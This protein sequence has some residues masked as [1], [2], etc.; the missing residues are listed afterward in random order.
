[1][2]KPARA[3]C[4]RLSSCPA[5]YCVSSAYITLYYITLSKQVDSLG[6]VDR[7]KVNLWTNG[8]QEMGC[9]KGVMWCCAVEV[10]RE[11]FQAPVAGGPC[12]GLMDG[13]MGL[14]TMSVNLSGVVGRFGLGSGVGDGR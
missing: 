3:G 11:S 6:V 8:M 4:R 14:I 1:M 7:A 12:W 2:R 9:C 13:G 5:V 10:V